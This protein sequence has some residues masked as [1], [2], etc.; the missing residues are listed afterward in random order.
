MSRTTVDR[1]TLAGSDGQTIYGNTHLPAGQPQAVLILCH[2][3]K[4]YK[5]Y[6]F[7]PRLA[8]AAA[9]RGLIAH[10]FNFSHAGMTEQI[11]T[12]AKPDLFQS[13]TWSRQIEDLQAVAG[14]IDSGQLAGQGLASVWFGHSRG[15][16]TVLLTAG[17][18][19]S[20]P[21][22]RMPRPTGVIAAASPAEPCSLTSKDRAT[23]R[24]DGRLPS[25]SSRTGQTLYVGLPW[26][27]EIEADPDAFD[28]KLAIARIACPVLLLHGAAD[29]TVGVAAAETL[30][31][32]AG[33]DRARR[34]V[35]DHAG[36]TFDCP[37]PLE[38]GADLP[39]A[40]QRLFDEVL[41]FAVSSE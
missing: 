6:G 40:T 30:A 7:F 28:P 9:D 15:G 4:G 18:A 1:W 39:P 41:R 31:K 26:L 19:F 8:E 33:E 12:F 38:P 11:E 13:D 35:I 22:G 2:G 34:V 5:D 14:A 27:E 3:F 37:N 25:P 21:D 24:K 17:R 20:D 23:L 36:H 29:A 32:A 10:R 16:L